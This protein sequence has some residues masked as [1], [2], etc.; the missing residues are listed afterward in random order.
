MGWPSGLPRFLF[1]RIER[2]AFEVGHGMC[3]LVLR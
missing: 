1:K 2:E 3:W